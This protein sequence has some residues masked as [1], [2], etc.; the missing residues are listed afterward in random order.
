M[1][2]VIDKGGAAF[3]YDCSPDEYEKGYAKQGNY[4]KDGLFLWVLDPQ[5]VAYILRLLKIDEVFVY[6]KGRG[7]IRILS[8]A[9]I[10]AFNE[11]LNK[12]EAESN[13]R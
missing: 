4:F 13:D 6:E 2:A 9:Y 7:N 3:I 10:E 12:R 8:E 1:T 11:V 5:K